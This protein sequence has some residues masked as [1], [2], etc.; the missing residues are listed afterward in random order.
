MKSVVSSVG[1]DG[2]F[3]YKSATLSAL[4]QSS[5][6]NPLALLDKNALFGSGGGVGGSPPDAAD[7]DDGVE[8]R[9]RANSVLSIRGGTRVE[10]LGQSLWDRE[11]LTSRRSS[12]EGLRRVST[13]EGLQRNLDGLDWAATREV[14][15]VSFSSS[16]ISYGPR[17]AR[18]STP[19]LEDR[20]FE[21]VSKSVAVAGRKP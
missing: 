21:M 2:N 7:H 20:M 9:P 13:P 18:A 8:P 17:H 6:D 10:G 15:P 11:S 3:H 14:S 1:K 19:S 12:T 4:R 16:G 5:Y